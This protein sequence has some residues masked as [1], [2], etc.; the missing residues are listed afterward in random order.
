MLVTTPAIVLSTIKYSDADL[1]ARL[2]TKEL[3]TQSYML[4]GIR[5]A[6][7]AKLRIAFFQPLTQLQIT[8]YHKG[9]GS[10]EYIKEARVAPMYNNIHHHVVKSSILLFFS[11]LLTQILS[12]QPADKHLYDYLATAFEFLDTSEHTANFAIKTLLDLSGYMGFLIDTQHIENPFFNLLEGTFDTNGMSPHHASEL[13]SQF[14]KEFLGT[15]F[16]AIHQIKMKRVQRN[17]LLHV[18]IDYFQI[19]LH[20]FK[21]PASL[22]ILKQLF[23]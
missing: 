2:Y 15:K 16:D 18:V 4:K 17:E 20:I 7:K 11:E 10:L 6:K 3:G 14:I 22:E 13:E 19:H 5:K 21:K 8:T 23:D 9:K 1:I 12:D